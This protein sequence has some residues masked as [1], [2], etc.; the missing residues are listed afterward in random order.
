MPS[1]YDRDRMQRR[2]LVTYRGAF[3][4]AEVL[5]TIER[6]WT[7]SAWSYAMLFDLRAMT[8]RPTL[9]D[10]K[11]IVAARDT[12]D[13]RTAIQRGPVALLVNDMEMYGRACAYAALAKSVI[14]IE[15]FRWKH[16]ADQWLDRQGA[17]P[18]GGG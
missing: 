5:E 9:D 4:V 12:L 3:L 7:D 17:G 18:G 1:E 15:V 6:I 16:E 10:L 13:R 2:L 14:P 8:G 11:Q